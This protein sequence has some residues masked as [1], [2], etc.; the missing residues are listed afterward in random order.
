M[1]IVHLS[2]LHIADEGNVLWE[3]DT[4]SHLKHAVEIIG[5]IN[6]I[7]AIIITGDLSNDGSIWSY[8]YI[9]KTLQ[10]L[11]IPTL[12]CP[13][14]HDNIEIMKL[15]N[16]NIF[17]TNNYETNINGYDFI[18]LNSTIPGMSRGLLTEDSLSWLER[19]LINSKNPTIIAF[20]H[21]CV[22]P[23]GWL[24]RK[25]LENRNDFV[26]LIS[27]Y[28]N[29]K[30]VL[31]G[32]IHYPFQTE[33]NGIKFSSASSVG[34]AFDKDLPKFQIAQGNEGFSLIDITERDIT[35]KNIRL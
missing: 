17:H 9:Y 25:I 23:G 11:K 14:N 8:E 6:N 12:C 28:R 22:E 19:K 29:V 20:H 34:F 26:R 24:N 27:D 7:D 3:T 2:D 13:G 31:Y 1:K 32:H 5:A 4:L 21:P 10:R 16:I 35:I 30:L 15:M 18:V 33:I